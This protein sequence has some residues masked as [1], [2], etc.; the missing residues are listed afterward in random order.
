MPAKKSQPKSTKHATDIDGLLSE[1]RRLRARGS[2]TVRKMKAL[3]AKIAA[4]R[5]ERK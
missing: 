2:E 5:D 3:E 4:M 1:V